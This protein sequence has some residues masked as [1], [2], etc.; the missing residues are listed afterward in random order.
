MFVQFH[1]IAP[2]FYKINPQFEK[3]SG[4][5]F[6]SFRMPANTGWLSAPCGQIFLSRPKI[7]HDVHSVVKMSVAQKSGG[8]FTNFENIYVNRN[9]IFHGIR[10]V[11]N[12]CGKPCGKCGKVEVFHKETGSFPKTPLSESCINL[13]INT[14]VMKW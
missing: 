5:F 11:E 14:V 13:C 12:L 10:A 4:F 2:N 9:C 8:I 1:I 6:I 7:L 3:I